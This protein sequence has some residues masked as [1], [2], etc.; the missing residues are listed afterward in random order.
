VCC[1]CLDSR[2]T[3]PRSID[4]WCRNKEQKPRI[5][6]QRIAESKWDGH[7]ITI[8]NWQGKSRTARSDLLR[9]C[10]DITGPRSNWTTQL[11]LETFYSSPRR[12]KRKTEE[13]KERSDTWNLSFYFFHFFFSWEILIT[14]VRLG[15]EIHS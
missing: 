9:K 3:L 6:N 10:G 13:E 11:S 8:I 2:K 14:V 12:K 15:C 5:N 4:K 7:T 1:C